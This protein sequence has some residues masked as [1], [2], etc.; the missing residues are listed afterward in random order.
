[1]IDWD[2]E[3]ITSTGQTVVCLDRNYK[4]KFG[5][6]TLFKVLPQPHLSSTGYEFIGLCSEICKACSLDGYNLGYTIRN[7]PVT[8]EKWIILWKDWP[9]A[10]YYET[11]EEANYAASIS[12]R[13]DLVKIMKVTWEE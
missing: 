1:M 13:T 12:V 10:W 11:E 6:L 3:V 8:V 9:S 4:S 2:K 7:K 5:T